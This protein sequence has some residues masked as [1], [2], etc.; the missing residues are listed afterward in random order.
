MGFIRL[1]DRD[2]LLRL[3]REVFDANPM[4]VPDT[5]IKPLALLV[6]D[7]ARVRYFGSLAALL[8]DARLPAVRRSKLANM[9]GQ[10][11]AHASL[12]VAASV[13]GALLAP[14]AGVPVP[15]GRL[16]AAFSGSR[17]EGVSVYFPNPRRD[18]V[19][20][21]ELGAALA[22]ARVPDTAT[23]TVFHDGDRSLLLVDSVILSDEIGISIRRR[24]ASAPAL[25]VEPF[26]SLQ[27]TTVND[28]ELTI[29]ASSWMPFAFSCL[30]V[31]VQ[32]DGLVTRVVHDADARRV[33]GFNRD[34]DDLSSGDAEFFHVG[35]HSD[36][37]AIDE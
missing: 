32:M 14:M 30:L 11:S 33:V 19:D 21:G 6:A 2:P 31:S 28:S 12:D 15:L 10:R 37:V 27:V 17:A 36:L 35:A 18:F 23:T 24:S 16:E 7:G 26:G 34:S 5:R 9:G 8:P 22:G 25:A 13:L 29:K 20:L 1:C 4:A 3:A